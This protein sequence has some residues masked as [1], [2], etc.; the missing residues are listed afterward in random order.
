[1]AGVLKTPYE[2]T[3]ERQTRKLKRM[4]RDWKTELAIV[5]AI[6]SRERGEEG[7]KPMPFAK[8]GTK[9]TAE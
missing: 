1:M 5:H 9:E 7:F 8:P 4:E 6:Q 2:K 3:M